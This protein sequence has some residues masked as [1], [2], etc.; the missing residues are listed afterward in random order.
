[1]FRRQWQ[2]AT[3]IG[4]V[5]FAAPFLGCAALARWALGWDAQ[6]SWLAGIAMSTTSVAVVHAVMLEFGLNTTDYGKTVLAACCARVTQ[7]E[8][9][10]AA[11]THDAA[12][13][14]G[15][16]R[17][18][19]SGPTAS[20]YCRMWADPSRRE[21]ARGEANHLHLGGLKNMLVAYGD[22]SLR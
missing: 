6:A 7:S 11:K 16:S 20:S 12:G 22:A 1:M 10:R 21:R 9:G 5:S 13:C 17:E 8:C 14:D 2:Q 18:R 15:E 4:L 19:T 3:W